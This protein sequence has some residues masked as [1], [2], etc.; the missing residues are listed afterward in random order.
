MVNSQR[1]IRLIKDKS[2]KGS[3]P[4]GDDHTSNNRNERH[5]SKPSLA[6][7]RHQIR[8]HS[9]E[10]RRRSP[11]RLIERHRQIPKRDVTTNHRC[12]KHEAKS[13]DLHELNPRSDRLHWD[14]LH[15]RNGN[16][17]EQRTRR[18]VA[19]GQEDWVLE[20]VIAQQV[21]VEQQNPNVGRIPRRHEP[22]REES[23]RARALR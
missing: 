6:L 22:D 16:V 19:H 7:Q 1:K 21:L 12:A 13:G 23:A 20:T 17:A 18:H 8:E 4:A 15:P 2:K 3:Y 11:N 10:K 14:H 9:R 5:V